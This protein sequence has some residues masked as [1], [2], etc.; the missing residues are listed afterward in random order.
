MDF[1][2][3]SVKPS[4]DLV[5][6]TDY[7]TLKSPAED[8]YI[9]TR[10]LWTKPRKSWRVTYKFL[11]PTDY[12]TLRTFFEQSAKGASV[13]FNWTNPVDNTTYVVR[14]KNDTLQASYVTYDR[15]N[16]EFELE[17]V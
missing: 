1:P 7:K 2:T 10:P 12:T 17:E 5:E 4:F 15:W 9:I 3:L 14:F 6:T 13:S 8:G 11:N 16:V